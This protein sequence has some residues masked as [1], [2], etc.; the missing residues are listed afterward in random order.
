MHSDK[1]NK[2]VENSQWIW[3]GILFSQL[4][5]MNYFSKM[6]IPMLNSKLFLICLLTFL[7]PL[8]SFV[9]LFEHWAACVWVN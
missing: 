9:K 7:P 2:I 3:E 8:I 4:P 1:K 5:D 6:N